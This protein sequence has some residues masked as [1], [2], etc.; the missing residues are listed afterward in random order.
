MAFVCGRTS[1]YIASPPP[2]TQGYESGQG[3]ETIYDVAC[4][5]RRSGERKGGIVVGRVRK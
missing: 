1:P 5:C 3:C 2:R 4:L